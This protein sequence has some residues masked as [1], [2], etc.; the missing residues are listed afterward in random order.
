MRLKLFEEYNNDKNYYQTIDS[1]DDFSEAE[2]DRIKMSDKTINKI[3]QAFVGWD[4][5]VGAFTLKNEFIY[6]MKYDESTQIKL[7]EI[8]DEYFYCLIT[9]F[10]KDIYYKCDQLEGLLKLFKDKGII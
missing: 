1:Y 3:K 4:I 7:I 8:E 6:L 9:D 10:D 5:E 2:Y